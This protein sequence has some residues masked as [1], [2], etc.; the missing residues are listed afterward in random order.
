LFDESKQ[1]R[2]ELTKNG[3]TEESGKDIGVLSDIESTVKAEKYEKVKGF[4]TKLSKSA[5]E[6]LKVLEPILFL[7]FFTKKLRAYYIWERMN[8]WCQKSIFK[9]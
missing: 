2:N 7:K 4:L 3:I 9:Q 1:L 6:L 5:F 8:T